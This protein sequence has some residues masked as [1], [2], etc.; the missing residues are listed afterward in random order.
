MFFLIIL[1]NTGAGYRLGS[2]FNFCRKS[3][4]IMLKSRPVL[5]VII[6]CLCLSMPAWAADKAFSPFEPEKQESGDGSGIPDPTQDVWDIL[7]QNRVEE[8]SALDAEAVSLT[9]KLPDASRELNEHLT[10]IENEYQRLVTISRVS[11]G[12]PMELSVVQ[13]RLLRLR[14]RLNLALE[15][16]EGTMNMLKARMTDISLLEQDTPARGESTVSPELRAFL[17]DLSMTENRLTTIQNRL[18]RILTPAKQLEENIT[19]LETR[20]KD[21]VPSLWREYYLQRSSRIYDVD[22]WLNIRK[23]LNSLQE[24]FAVRMSAELPITLSG[25]AGVLLR[26]LL[27][28]LPLQLLIFLSRKLSRNWPAPLNTGWQRLSTHSLFWLSL[29]FSFHFAAWSGIGTF[30]VLSVVGT[31]LL[32]FGQMALAWDLYIFERSDLPDSTPLWPLFVPLLWGLLLLLFNLPGPFLGIVWLIVLAVTLWRDHLRPLPDIPFPLVINLLRFQTVMLWIAV[33]MTMLGWGRLSILV[34]MAYAALAVSLQQAV[35]FMRLTNSIS[36][37]LP[38]EGFKALFSGLVLALALPAVLVFATLATGLWILAYPGGQFL[39]SQLA[40]MDFS[41]GQTTFNVIQVLFIVSAFYVTRSVI[42]VGRSLIAELPAHGIRLDYSL[43]GPVQAGF[44]YL[45]WALFGLYTLSAL[46]FSLSSLAMVA[47]GL[48][49]GIGFGMQNIINNFISGLLMIFGQTLREGD[50]IEVGQN[51]TGV[52]KKINVRSTMVETFDNA[53]IFVPNAEF[54]SGRLTNWTRNGRMV[55]REI[56]VGVAYGSDI[57]LVVRLLK[58]VAREHPK[59]LAYPE[60]TVLFKDFGGSS[61]DF[62]L[63]F[64]V[65]DILHGSGISS[66]IRTTIDRRFAEEKIEIAF[67]Q[68]DVHLRQNEELP[69]LLKTRKSRKGNRTEAE[70][71]ADEADTVTPVADMPKGIGDAPAQNL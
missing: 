7:L 57:Q 65:G 66:D 68:M 8:L 40:S 70:K 50:V 22:S 28:F 49:V 37:R 3:L 1:R 4:F 45:L 60:P 36:G 10:S 15:P 38:Q 25:W 47:G 16:L 2:F 61:L 19:E 21:S 67:P 63:L 64:W 48:S 31:L 12:Q 44:T 33:L 59:V 52:V 24:T 71:S 27:L 35:G 39:L 30:H 32:S 20:L 5:F 11:R 23:N 58:E 13:E 18:N 26:G 29:G 46:G 6:F 69:V 34:S 43:I 42:S 55:R 9:K 51:L 54:L 41:V 56:S 62:S 53:V 14:E 17:Q